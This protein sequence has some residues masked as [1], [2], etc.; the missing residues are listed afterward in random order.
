MV[1]QI[2]FNISLNMVNDHKIP[3]KNKIFPVWKFKFMLYNL[4]NA[5]L[6]GV[7]SFEVHE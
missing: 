1:S 2:P 6:L 5:S 7:G 4:H 3:T